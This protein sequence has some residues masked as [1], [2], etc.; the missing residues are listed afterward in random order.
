MAVFCVVSSIALQPILPRSSEYA[1]SDADVTADRAQQSLQIAL[2]DHCGRARPKHACTLVGR[3]LGRE[4]H[5]RH[6]RVLARERRRHAGAVGAGEPVVEQHEVDVELAQARR[7][8]SLSAAVPTTSS[9]GSRPSR[10]SIV[11]R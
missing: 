10:S 2:L 11:E 3:C 8:A 1:G 6:V 9:P 4:A 5:D 7:A